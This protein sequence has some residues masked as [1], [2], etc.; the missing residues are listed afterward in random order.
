MG[1]TVGKFA[2]YR[3]RLSGPRPLFCCCIRRMEQCGGSGP[4][5]SFWATVCEM[6][7]LQPLTCLAFSAPPS[8]LKIDALALLLCLP[9]PAAYMRRLPQKGPFPHTRLFRANLILNRFCLSTSFSLPSPPLHH[10][11]PDQLRLHLRDCCWTPLHHFLWP[12]LLLSRLPRLACS[13]PHTGCPGLPAHN[14]GRFAAAMWVRAPTAVMIVALLLDV[15]RSE[16]CLNTCGCY[17][18][19]C[20]SYSNGVCQDGGPGS[21]YST[22][23]LGTD[24]SDCEADA[25]LERAARGASLLPLCAYFLP[26]LSAWQVALGL[27]DQCADTPTATL[28]WHSSLR[29]CPPQQSVGGQREGP[30]R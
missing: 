15:A 10:H 8:L 6:R 25:C 9:M 4:L 2:S 16:L 13:S 12:L 27:M 20:S 19:D 30:C 17:R 22:C 1:L 18:T 14:R 24:C 7:F 29:S 11:L 5:S 28:T 21:A 26:A 3:P 23:A